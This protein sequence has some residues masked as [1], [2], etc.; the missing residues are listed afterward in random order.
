MLRFGEFLQFRGSS[1]SVDFG[2]FTELFLVRQ[3]FEKLNQSGGTREF[4][5]NVRD[6][7]LDSFQLE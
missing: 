6:Y 1:R 2:K 5:G 4:L 7:V 3:K